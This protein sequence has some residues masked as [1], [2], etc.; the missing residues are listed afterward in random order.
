MSFR[1]K[2]A[3]IA[4]V[5]TLPIWIYYFWR[6]IGAAL[7]GYLDGD[8]VFWLFVWCLVASMV[9]MLPLNIIAAVIARQNMDAA[10]DERERAIDA[11]ANRIGLVLIEVMMMAVVAASGVIAEFARQTYAA[12]TVGAITVMLINAVL[13]VLAFSALAREAIQIVQFRM[14]D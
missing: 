11:F 10:P 7:A 9:I 1:E 5:G 2:S 4:V 13:F 3:W 8:A 12:D 6:V 14:L